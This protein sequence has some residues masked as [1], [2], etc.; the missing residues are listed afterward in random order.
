MGSPD[1]DESYLVLESAE[2]LLRRVGASDTEAVNTQDLFRLPCDVNFNAVSGLVQRTKQGNERRKMVNLVARLKQARSSLDLPAKARILQVLYTLRGAAVQP[3]ASVTLDTLRAAKL[4]KKAAADPFPQAPLPKQPQAVPTP[5][6]LRM[7]NNASVMPMSHFIRH[8]V[9]LMQGVPSETIPEESDVVNAPHSACQIAAQQLREL[10]AMQ[11]RVKADLGKKADRSLLH[12]SLQSG[13]RSQMQAFDVEMG[14]LMA[15]CNAPEKPL[16]LP[17]ALLAA[18]KAATDLGFIRWMQIAADASWS[19]GGALAS[20]LESFSRHA[21]APPG[22]FKSLRDAAYKPL[23]HMVCQWV[24]EGILDD[25]HEEFFVAR[26]REKDVSTS[27][28]AWWEMKYTLREVLLPPFVSPSLAEDILLAGKSIN[29]LRKLC[30]DPFHMPPSVRRLLPA[31]GCIAPADLS[32]L[33]RVAKAAV[34]ERVLEV[35]FDD[36]RLAEHLHVARSL[37]LLAQG[38]FFEEVYLGRAGS[39]LRAPHSEVMKRKYQLTPAIEEC[40]TKTQIGIGLSIDPCKYVEVRMQDGDGGSDLGVDRF[41]LLYICPQP[42]RTV[43]R[44]NLQE[45]HYRPIFAFI[46]KIRKMQKDLVQGRGNFK[47]ILHARCHKSMARRPPEWWMKLHRASETASH[48]AHSMLQFVNALCSYML[49]DGV[50]VLWKDFEARA[51]AA[52]TFDDVIKGHH[53]TIAALYRHALLDG[54]CLCPH[55]LAH[56]LTRTSGVP[57]TEAAR[58]GCSRCRVR[59]PWPGADPA[60]ARPGDAVGMRVSYFYLVFFGG[61]S[62]GLLDTLSAEASRCCGRREVRRVVAGSHERERARYRRDCAGGKPAAQ[63]VRSGGG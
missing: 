44:L 53:D 16:S 25:P 39:M 42:L 58:G 20:T 32:E 18:D 21:A 40:V 10:G 13:I 56:A 47:Q 4:Q 7:P 30:N 38:D 60:Q 1:P 5:V 14:E 24:T 29:F 22:L 48:V 43:L 59:V 27:H 28:D 34:D 35:V 31:E 37:G 49:T 41:Y 12:Q 45:S 17:R 9:Y 19:K 15:E 52:K 36:H 23:L 50:G 26:A 57:R 33:V 62:G 3:Q 63:E 2:L 51:K 54:V 6:P 55:A 8:G 11:A 46:W 61:E